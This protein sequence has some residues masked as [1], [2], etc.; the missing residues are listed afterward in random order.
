MP[1]RYVLLTR[2]GRSRG[3]MD[4]A[5]PARLSFLHR[6]ELAQCIGWLVH[7]EQ[8][9]PELFARWHQR[10][11]RDWMLVC[12]PLSISSIAQQGQTLFTLAAGKRGP[13]F[14]S[15]TKDLRLVGP[16]WIGRTQCG[17][18][19]FQ[20]LKVGRSGLWAARASGADRAGE[21]G[22]C[23]NRRVPSADCP[24]PGWPPPPKRCAPGRSVRASPSAPRQRVVRVRSSRQSGAARPERAE[25]PRAARSADNRKPSS[26]ARGS[27][28]RSICAHA[29]FRPERRFVSI[30]S[31]QRP[32]RVKMWEGMCSACGASAARPA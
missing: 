4:G 2:L 16:I 18:G 9:L 24:A 10:S 7:Q 30:D 14:G 31:S 15:E 26:Q 25:P 13:T 1:P 22:V 6:L 3:A 20:G 29:Q 19:R 27:R 32:T 5:E 8:H 17:R 23:R 12:T 21:A 11:R 28:R